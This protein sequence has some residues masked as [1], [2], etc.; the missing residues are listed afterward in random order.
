MCRF[1]NPFIKPVL[2]TLAIS[3]P[4]LAFATGLNW[5][6]N[7]LLPTFST[8]APIL[9]CIDVTS[10]S[11]AD[12]DL[13]AS[14]E[15][16]VNR[17]QPRIACI[18][19]TQEGGFTW[20]NLHNL[21][22]TMVNG[23][24]TIVKYRTN[25]T[26]LV[27]TDPAQPDT[28]NLATTIAGVNNELIC[29]P[30]LLATLT[31]SPYS[32]P[33]VDDL[34]GR[35]S[36]KYQV[37][38]YLYTNYWPQ[39][40]HRL[41]SGMNPGVHG[42]FR[43]Y[44][45]A[46]KSATVWLDPG[47][48]N[49]TDKSVLGMFLSEMTP[50]NG[51]YAGW[52]PSEANGLNWIYSYGIPVLA[53]DFLV[54]ASVFSGVSRPINIPEIPPPP[55]LQN[56]VYV[57]MILSDGDNI[58]YMQ[59]AMKLN[60]D[61]PNRG[62]IP[63]GWTVS[64]LA[65]DMDPGMLNFYWSTASTNDCLIS[66]PS[67]AGYTHMQ[68]WNP[69]YMAAFAKVSD[70][71]LQRSGLRIITVWDQ[72]TA[73]VAQSFA[74]NCPSL[75]GLTDQSG[76]TYTSVNNGLRTIGLTV[77]YSSDTNAIYSGI[78][79][80]AKTWN[81]TA[82]LFIA[83]QAVVW[84]LGPTQLRNIANALDPNKYVLV[85]PDHLF[86]L[87]NRI[88]GKPSAV[89]ESATAITA[90]SAA[91][92][93]SV[94][95]NATNATA[96]MEWGTNNSYGF[97]T[98]MTNV[99]LA[100]ALVTVKL[101]VGGLS[102]QRTYHYRVVASNALGMVW[103]ADQQFTTGG[104]LQVWGGGTLGETNPPAGLTNIV[105][106][107]AGANHGLGLKNDG[108]VVA[109]GNNNFGQTN[110]PVGLTNVVEVAGGIQHSVALLADGT[111][112]A[113]GDNTYGQTNVPAGLSN[114]L[115]IAAG[116]YHNLALKTDQT[117]TAWGR[118]DFGQTNVPAALSNVVSVAAGY[119]HSL[120]LKADGTVTAWGNN[121]YGQTNVPAGLNGVVAVAAGQYHSLALKA[122]EILAT[123]FPPLRRWVADSLAGSDGTMVGI[124]TDVLGGKNATQ[125]ST[126]NRPRLYSNVINGH[127]TVRFTS[128]SSQYMTVSAA[129]S[130]ISAAGSFT[131]IVVFKTSTPGANST[132][133]YQNTGIIGCEQP[134]EVP[135]WALCLNGAQLGAGL[136]AGASGCGSDL[137][138]YGGNVTDGNPHIAMYVR[139]GETLS[140]YVDGVKV[141]S[142]TG[143]CMA[144]RGNYNF[145]IGAMV[146]GSLCFNGDIAEIQIY[147]RGFNPRE[148]TDATEVLAANYGIGG[149][150]GTVV[151]WG[152][153]FYGQTNAP[154]NL[155]NVLTVDGGDG[156]NLALK[157][158]GTVAGWGNNPLGQT[159]IPA[160]LTNV[161]AI[162]GGSTFALAIGNQSPAAND[163]T[164]SGYVD[165]DL[166]IKLP[167]TNPDGNPLNYQIL[168]LPVTGT[169]YQN[170]GGVRGAAINA[171]NTL[172]TDAS[173]QLIFAPAVAATGN[174]Y[175]MFNF[176]ADDGLFSSSPAQVTVNI[177][178]PA[179]PQFSDLSWSSGQPGWFQSEFFRCLKRDLQCLG[180]D[181]SGGL[182]KNRHSEGAESG[183][184]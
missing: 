29:D 52:W 145:Q 94:T 161:A 30:S 99:G 184:V 157:P 11:G 104:R 93:G 12:S 123:N 148:I 156:F 170:S 175:A 179:A 107:G 10:V 119:S 109:W 103:G 85:R 72:V 168:S 70:A 60:W 38:Q 180:G 151:V 54:N 138:F 158:N 48:L 172:L 67:G 159:N 8:P 23:Y 26:G 152:N 146:A 74:T 125:T 120:A 43:D 92:T 96:W 53:S 116:G 183:P 81:G 9:D 155:T 2:V 143:L 49:P 3:L 160:T 113:W 90:G 77:A 121:N 56:K 79:N 114:V 134:N 117:V 106:I 135:D 165:H 1:I 44:I 127:K 131:L 124:W 32:L 28:V 101:P 36:D 118:N 6:D 65:S 78:T 178:L 66:G 5:P 154:N 164:N 69:V 25:F 126:G 115:A 166:L 27:V 105:G 20:L 42:N 57:S 169:L 95:P 51:V 139:S 14:M 68:K 91:L 163:V 128:S 61:N 162:A 182:G 19:N 40:T 7:Q 136:G 173:G 63:L 132:L 17:T 50:A 102:A 83:V 129:D 4:A 111:V 84:D 24:A 153:N 18:I 122:D 39:C 108:T 100:G 110:V 98:A 89:T 171:I 75:L 130:P 76:G 181:Q 45:V 87:Y 47:T 37:Y 174:P 59:H 141:A 149:T 34:R 150:A 140:L 137:S 133:F 46:T 33:V 176:M 142:Q 62:S 58:Q 55:P 41:I 82:P 64:A 88:N 71:Y 21:S 177:G 112:A 22:Y 97:K 15:G 16:I 13:F 35:F 144:A 86:M 80:A 31:N 73:G 167:V 147:D